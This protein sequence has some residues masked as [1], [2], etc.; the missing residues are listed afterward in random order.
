MGELSFNIC[1]QRCRKFR[2][3]GNRTE[4]SRLYSLIV[5]RLRKV[6]LGKSVLTSN[7]HEKLEIFNKKKR[8]EMA[9]RPK[10]P[11]SSYM[12]WLSSIRESIKEDNP[13]IKVTEVTRKAG[14]L[15]R[16]MTDKS[17]WEAKAAKAKEDYVCAM[18]EYKANGGSSDGQQM[19]TRRSKI[20][21][22]KKQKEQVSRR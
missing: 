8:T 2:V 4:I 18:R 10:R 17:E 12:L 21:V 6:F 19:R 9:E 3:S 13:G 22:I 15:W 11:L 14:E 1:K 16:S 5:K 20:S 7:S